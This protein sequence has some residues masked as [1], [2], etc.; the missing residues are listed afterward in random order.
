[1][2]WILF[3]CSIALVGCFGP[4]APQNVWGRSGKVYTAPNVCAALVACKNANEESCFYDRNVE[5]TATG[6]VAEGG[7]K[8]EK[9]K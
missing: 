2:K 5:I 3:A 9:T 8:E 1:M 4:P 6:T 7:C